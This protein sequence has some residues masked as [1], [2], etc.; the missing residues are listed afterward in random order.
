MIVSVSF[1]YQL[2]RR[3]GS[4]FD[5]LQRYEN[6]AIVAFIVYFCI[7]YT[8]SM[9]HLRRFLLF[10]CAVAGLS[11]VQAQRVASR[12]DCLPSADGSLRYRLQV[13]G[14][15]VEPEGETYARL[16]VAGDA[17]RSVRVGAPLLPQW[18]VVVSLPEGARVTWETVEDCV[19][20]LRTTRP[21]VPAQP[22]AVKGRLAP[23]AFDRAVYARRDFYAEPLL[24]LVE[25]GVM[26]GRR[27]VRL[28]FSPIAY[29]P[30]T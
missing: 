11:A 19:D 2:V 16:C 29:N 6:N 8:T 17:D 20:T 27:L 25:L 5:A 23:F 18:N 7:L 10:F 28:C 21:L 14:V 4:H 1:C 15:S 9:K 30:S 12:L 26:R 3:H 13:E 24:R 22:S